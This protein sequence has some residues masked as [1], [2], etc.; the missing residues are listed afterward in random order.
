MENITPKKRTGNYGEAVVC[1][2]LRNNGYEILEQNYTK[3]FGEIDIIA[4]RNDVLVFVEVKTRRYNSMIR[5][6]YAVDDQKRKKIIK[7]ADAFLSEYEDYNSVRFDVAE[8]TVTNSK[9]PALLELQYYKS[10]FDASGFYT[11]N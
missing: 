10:A 9:I 11:V 3:P 2:Y 1:A 8:V 4:K 5:G 7:T 6:V